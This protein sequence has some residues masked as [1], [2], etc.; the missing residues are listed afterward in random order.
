MLWESGLQRVWFVQ[1]RKKAQPLQTEN[2]GLISELHL[3]SSTAAQ[4]N[5]GESFG[6]SIFIGAIY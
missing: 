6:P 5:S 3:T 1:N 4:P 2:R